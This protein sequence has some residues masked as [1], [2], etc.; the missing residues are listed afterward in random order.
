VPLGKILP[1]DYLTEIQL[2]ENDERGPAL[3]KWWSDESFGPDLLASLIPHAWRAPASPCMW[4]DESCWVTLFRSAGFIAETDAT[5]PPGIDLPPTTPIEIW[6][7]S[8]TAVSPGMSWAPELATARAFYE[9]WLFSGAAA[10]YKTVVKPNAVL[11]VFTASAET[12][13][14]IDPSQ[15]DEVEILETGFGGQ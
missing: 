3:W 5:V 10:L 13:V 8:P 7:G 15:L 4:L 1:V 14:V 2:L 11:A 9:K 12:E 6:R